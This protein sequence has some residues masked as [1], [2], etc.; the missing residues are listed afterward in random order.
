M[1]PL[2]LFNPQNIL[3]NEINIQI[4]FF[5]FSDSPYVRSGVSLETC[6]TKKGRACLWRQHR[7]CFVERSALLRWEVCCAALRGLL[8]CVERSAVLASATWPGAAMETYFRYNNTLFWRQ[9]KQIILY[10]FSIMLTSMVYIER[11]R[12]SSLVHDLSK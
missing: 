11:S 12:K 5:F 4:M 1:T 10:F 9:F 6:L 3:K 2:I 7:L 8:C